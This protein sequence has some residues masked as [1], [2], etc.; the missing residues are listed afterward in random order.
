MRFLLFLPNIDK[1]V[2]K[3]FDKCI[4]YKRKV[5]S[6]NFKEITLSKYINGKTELLERYYL[7]EKVHKN[8]IVEDEEKKDVLLSKCNCEIDIESYRIDFN[9]FT[10]LENIKKIIC[11]LKNI[12]IDI[13]KLDKSGFSYKLDLIPFF[14]NELL[15]FIHTEK[16]NYINYIFGQALQHRDLRSNFI[17]KKQDFSNFEINTYNNSI[18]FNIKEEVEKI[19]G[20]WEDSSS[21][22]ADSTY[23]KNYTRL[24]PEN[25]Y[26]DS[27]ANTPSVQ[28]MIY[29]NEYINFNDWIDAQRIHEKNE[30]NKNTEDAYGEFRHIIPSEQEIEFTKEKNPTKKK[31]S[32]NGT[33]SWSET[34]RKNKAQ[35]ILGNKGEL[36]MYNLLCVEFGEDNVRAISEAFVDLGILKAGQGIS[37]QYDISYKNKENN[38]IFVEVKTG[39]EKSFIITQNELE[40]A[41]E[42]PERFELYLVYDVDKKEPKYKKIPYKF[43]KNPK[44]RFK[45]IVERIEVNF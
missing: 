10:S 1:I 29:F 18:H 15:N 33:Y 36:L 7:F 45:E 31:S 11:L 32:R 2:I 42:N 38:E 21:E 17:Q 3:L 27:I 14:K 13:D 26:A 9:H 4:V 8:K 43:W 24:N 40:F 35:K 22:D 5:E 25:L 19:F 6:N 44:F 20:K 39:N 16:K 34:E 28:T 37:G 23:K 30:Q 12:N 41:K